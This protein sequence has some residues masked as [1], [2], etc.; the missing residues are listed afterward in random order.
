MADIANSVHQGKEKT[1]P[2]QSLAQSQS[3]MQVL[4][5][6]IQKLQTLKPPPKPKTKREQIL[7]ML[8]TNATG[9]GGTSLTTPK[10]RSTKPNLRYNEYCWSHGINPS[11]SSCKCKS[12]KPR[13]QDTAIYTNQ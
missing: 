10:T 2:P 13:D 9:V 12:K 3:E 11:H 5:I 6:A 1:P 4:L 7:A 8:I